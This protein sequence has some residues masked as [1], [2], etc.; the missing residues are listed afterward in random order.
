M[1]T[2]VDDCD[3][4]E[5]KPLRSLVWKV[6]RTQFGA[7]DPKQMLKF[8]GVVRESWDSTSSCRGLR[9]T[10]ADYTAKIQEERCE[11]GFWSDSCLHHCWTVRHTA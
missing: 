5:A 10:H 11:T 7:K 2:Y 8:L 4:D 3:L 6:V 9:L 1:T